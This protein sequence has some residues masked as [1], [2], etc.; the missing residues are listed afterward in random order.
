MLTPSNQPVISGCVADTN[1]VNHT[2]I[3]PNYGVAGGSTP[4]TTPCSLPCFSIGGKL[5]D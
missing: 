4:T 1:T 3:S 5:L 2:C